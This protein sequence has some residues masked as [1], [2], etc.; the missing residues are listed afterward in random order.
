MSNEYV[1]EDLVPIVS[2][3]AELYT[4]KESS[5][6]TYECASQ[7]MEAVLYCIE[8]YETKESHALVSNEEKTKVLE[9]KLA[10]EI[11]YDLVCEE[12]RAAN[13]L[14][15]SIRQQFDSYQSKCLE[16]TILKGMPEFFMR[17]DVRFAPMDHLLTLDYPLLI[18]LEDTCGI[19]R[20]YRYLECVQLEQEFLSAFDRETILSILA[21]YDNEYEEGFENIV[22]IV[23]RTILASIIVEKNPMEIG[24]TE[25]EYK[26]ITA[27]LRGKEKEKIEDELGFYLKILIK[28]Y[29]A[30]NMKLYE[31]VKEDISDF[32]VELL[33]AAQYDSLGALFPKR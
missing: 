14:F 10:Y 18:A 1:I 9:A 19:H 4:S 6:I 12:V 11:G 28:Q 20:I 22:K 31:Y 23:Y 25:H 29:Y 13:Q 3:L 24:F 33:N 2:H 30:E 7:L 17:Y 15:V 32:V 8:A 21:S 27:F 16:E 26:M 5:S